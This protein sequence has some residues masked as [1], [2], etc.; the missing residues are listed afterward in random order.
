MPSIFSRIIA[1]EIPGEFIYTGE[2]WVAILDI[3]PS[4]PG[5]TLV[6]PIHEA[7]Y[8]A[9]LPRT[10]LADLGVVL[11]QITAAVKKAS[12]APAVHVVLNDGSA[13][14]QEVPH[15]HFHVIPRTPN[16]GKKSGLFGGQPATKDA[17]A[18]MAGRIR[19]ALGTE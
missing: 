3:R 15:V 10:V 16:D 5:H 11:G 6:I 19:A 14:G 17:L 4:A 8:L 7:Q 1:G 2:R 9:E 12:G 13:A 18:E